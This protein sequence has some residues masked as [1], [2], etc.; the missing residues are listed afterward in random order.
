M[1]NS[2]KS[3]MNYQYQ[4]N[5]SLADQNRNW[6]ERMANSAHQREINDLKAAGLNPVLSVTGG[7]GATTP[8]GSTASVSEGAGYAS[9]LAHLQAAQLNSAATLGAARYNYLGTVYSSDKNSATE[10][11][12]TLNN[13][14]TIPSVIANLPNIWNNQASMW[15]E[16]FGRDLDEFI[17]D[18]LGKNFKKAKGGTYNSIDDLIA[19]M[20]VPA[21]QKKYINSAKSFRP[22]KSNKSAY[23]HRYR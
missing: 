18:K 23:R 19:N 6:Q 13:A 2:S 11:W 14:N 12:K 8:T 15:Y 21:N 9:A 10:M 16:L 7:N 4:L 20:E 1:L 17:N 22:S 5:K 3:M